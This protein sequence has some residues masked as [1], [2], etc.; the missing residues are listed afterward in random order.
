MGIITGLEI[1]L[2]SVPSWEVPV[3]VVGLMEAYKGLWAIGIV[4]IIQQ[5][6]SGII[7]PK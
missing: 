4:L 1:I 2:T 6:E 7:T 3:V 5:L